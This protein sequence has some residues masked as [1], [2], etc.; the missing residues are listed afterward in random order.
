MVKQVPLWRRL[1]VQVFVAIFVGIFV[2]AIWPKTGAAMRPLGD[3]FI[4]L[5]RMMIGPVIFCTI[6]H[7]IGSMHDMAKVGRIGLKAI[8][9]F[10]ATSTFALLLGIGAAHLVHPGVGVSFA[11]SANSAA[12]SAYVHRAS[13]DGLVAHLM[14]IIPTTFIDAFTKGDLL[15]VLLVSVLFGVALSQMGE[16]GHGITHGIERVGRVF[17]R[18]IG[19]IVYLAPVGTFGAMAYTIGAFGVKSLINL[20]EL[21]AVFYVTS[22]LFVVV[23]MGALSSYLGFSIFKFLGYIREE[24]LIVIGTASSE[25]VLPN[26]MRKLEELGAPESVVGLVVPMGYSFNLCGTNIYMTLGILFLAQAT[27]THLTWGQEAMILAISML[28]SKGAAGVTGAGF[29]TLAATLIIVPE[30]PIAVTRPAAWC[31]PVY[32]PMPGRDELRLEWR[33]RVGCGTLGKRVE[34]TQAG[35]S[36]CAATRSRNQSS[37]SNVW[38]AIAMD[39]RSFGKSLVSAA[40][41]AGVGLGCR[42]QRSPRRRSQGWLPRA[43]GISRFPGPA[44]T[45]QRQNSLGW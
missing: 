17:F 42:R 5:I 1:Y 18:M 38:E 16:A 44:R 21:V 6:V 13:N 19:I 2:G 8:I 10:E 3:G 15:Q 34:H 27:N 25:T 26:L 37:K 29:V 11:S 40:A 24:L 30:I 23:V 4:A 7:G 45:P 31:G 22:I 12:V 9:W 35:K 41:G 36:I 33:R 39:R 14:A 43:I 32:E 28:T 20:G